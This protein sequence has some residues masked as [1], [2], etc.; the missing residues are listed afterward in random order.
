MKL[1]IICLAALCGLGF[2]FGPQTSLEAK[3]HNHFSVNFSPVYSA[4]AQTYIVEQYPTYVEE[5][6]YMAPHGYAYPSY[7]ERVYVQPAPRVRY[8]YPQRPAYYSG[9]SVGFGVR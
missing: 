6:V 9:F 5:R 2:I 1:P 3:H 4:P 8:V 7:S